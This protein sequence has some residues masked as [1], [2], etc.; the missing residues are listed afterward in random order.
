MNKGP[1]QPSLCC[2]IFKKWENFLLEKAWIVDPWDKKGACNQSCLGS[3]SCWRYLC[4]PEIFC[5]M[6][7]RLSC[8]RNNV[9]ESII[10]N[11]VFKSL[12]SCPILASKGP[13]SSTSSTYKITRKHQAIVRKDTYRLLSAEDHWNPKERKNWFCHIKPWELVSNHVRLSLD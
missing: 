7:D 5:H 12:W 4:W 3:R 8:P 13:I 2:T 10:S 9:E 6:I 11:V 1:N